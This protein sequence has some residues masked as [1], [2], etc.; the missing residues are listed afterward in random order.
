MNFK[1][2]V[3]PAYLKC[4]KYFSRGHNLGK[5]SIIRKIVKKTESMLKSD[6]T[7]VQGNKMF[8]DK[9]D[10]LDLSI[11]GVYNEFDT[12]L[13]KEQ[14]KSG[15]R[16][17]DLGANIGYH[18]LLFAKLVGESGSVY[19]FEP[20]P[21]NFELLKKNI[22]VNKFQNIISE[23]HAISNTNSNCN[24]YV[25]RFSSGGN[26]ICEPRKPER[27]EKKPIII[28]TI[29]LDDYFSE[30]DLVDK[31]DFIKIDIE[32][33]ELKALQGMSKILKENKNLKIFIEFSRRALEYAG[34]DPRELLNLLENEGF[35]IYYVD[36]IKNKIVIADK[37]LLMTSNTCMIKTINLFCVKET[38]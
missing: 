25:G 9:W 19:S 20:E 13:I 3:I 28:Q 6:F 11:N 37:N 29:I 31:I 30:I 33:S 38:K 23:P 34:S 18:S 5:Y 10:S 2:I 1:R 26:L 12:K 35:T 24:L 8:L 16:V 7:I 4:I 21:K 17:I 14:V 22:I 27:F 32:G 36:D 15:Y